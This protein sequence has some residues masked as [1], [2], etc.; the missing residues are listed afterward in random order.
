LIPHIALFFERLHPIMP[1]FTRAWLFARLDRSE[2]QQDPQF[3]ALLLAMSALAL[4]Q[5]V[6]ASE[7]AAVPE[8]QARAR[9]L[10]EE[11][12]RMRASALFGQHATIDAVLTSFYIFACLFGMKEDNAAWFRLTEAVTL[13]QLLKLHL[14]G[15]YEGLEKGERERRLRTYWILCITESR[16]YAL[17]RGHPITFRGRPSQTMDA[18]SGGLQIGEL[19]DFP[20]R[21]LKLFDS[22]DED[23]IDCWN[24]RCAGRACRTLDAARALALHKQLSEPLEGAHTPSQE[25]FEV[26]SS[27]TSTWKRG[28]IQSADVLITQQWLL[29]RLWRLAMSHGLIDPAASEPALRVDAPVTLAHAALAICN[30]L[31]MPSIEAHGI[32]YLE[33][34]YDIATTLAVLSQYAPE[35]VSQPTED[36][37]SVSQLLAEYVALFRRFRGGDHP[38]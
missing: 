6:Q 3:A 38:F 25:S 35:V 29:N 23:F 34:L 30:R 14:P 17:Q 10:L 11:A 12:C 7:Q 1:I 8:Q 20:V 2:H 27:L 4:T 16:A 19:D 33:K 9:Q 22:V 13:G 31:S 18:V 24:G 37:L 36:G 15:S 32:G 26:F 21:H 5:P 28:E